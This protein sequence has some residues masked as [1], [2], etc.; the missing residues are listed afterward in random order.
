MRIGYQNGHQKSQT[1]VD[2]RP[3]KVPN[4]TGLT[5]PAH[6]PASTEAATSA[7]AHVGDWSYSVDITDCVCNAFVNCG[8][9]TGLVLNLE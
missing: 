2:Q 6:A 3:H 1:E 5:Y 9:N 4:S 8:L 7:P